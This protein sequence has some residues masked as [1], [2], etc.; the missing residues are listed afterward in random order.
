MRSENAKPSILRPLAVLVILVVL[1]SL[2]ALAVPLAAAPFTA[3]DNG[4]ELWVSPA[5]PYDDES[6]TLHYLVTLPSPCYSSE[7]LFQRGNSF[8][9]ELGSCPILP[10][11]RPEVIR[12]EDNFGAL[13]PG[14][15]R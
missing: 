10:I 3:A 2:A 8:D 4:A 13:A 12:I 6:V 11:P 9:L 1:A 5:Q 14:A 7:G 15:Y